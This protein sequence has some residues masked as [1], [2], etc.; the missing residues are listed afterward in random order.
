MKTFRGGG[1]KKRTAKTVT[2]GLEAADKFGRDARPFE[3]GEV[4]YIDKPDKKKRIT[5]EGKYGGRAAK[6]V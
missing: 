2:K 4:D 3:E 5:F 1:G 6:E